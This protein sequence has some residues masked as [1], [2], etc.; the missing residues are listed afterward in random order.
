MEK[1]NVSKKVIYVCWNDKAHASGTYTWDGF[2]SKP[3]VIVPCPS[4]GE[5]VRIT[6]KL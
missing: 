6:Q 1:Y 3:D 5:T 2:S 4:C